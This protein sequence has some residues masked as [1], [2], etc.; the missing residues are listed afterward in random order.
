MKT[1]GLGGTLKT[2]LGRS[3]LQT[4]ST[5]KEKRQLPFSMEDLEQVCFASP[6]EK[7]IGRTYLR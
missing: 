5:P 4:L 3:R 7:M 1:S 6:R 2:G